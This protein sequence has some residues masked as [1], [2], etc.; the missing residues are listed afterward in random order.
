MA[1][2]PKSW[3]RWRRSGR[4]DPLWSS[5]LGATTNKGLRPA[6]KALACK[7]T[8]TRPLSHPS[9]AISARWP[10]MSRSQDLRPR[11][12]R[13]AREMREPGPTR[14]LELCTESTNQRKSQLMPCAWPSFLLKSVQ[15]Y[16]ARRGGGRAVLQLFDGATG[17]QSSRCLVWQSHDMYYYVTT[18]EVSCTYL[19]ISVY[20][21]LGLGCVSV[22]NRYY[23][24]FLPWCMVSS[25]G[26][27]VTF[28]L[29]FSFLNSCPGSCYI[30]P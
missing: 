25:P 14:T 19:H 30:Y 29:F 28:F 20:I 18:K 21:L 17:A 26:L 10:R 2:G 27:S 24:L 16:L 8:Y 1:S 9:C 7:W 6:P 11:H 4:H 22:G 15:P 13:S 12:S 5:R 3:L 23:I